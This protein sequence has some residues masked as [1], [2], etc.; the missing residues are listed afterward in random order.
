MA[1]PIELLFGLAW[2]KHKFNHMQGALMGGH[3]GA[4]WWIR[5]YRL[6]AVVMQPSVKLLWLLLVFI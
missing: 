3:L 5:C 6:C 2:R 1:E 4:T